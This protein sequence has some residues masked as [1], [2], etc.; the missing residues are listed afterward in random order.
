M[1]HGGS[2]SALATPPCRAPSRSLGTSPR[3]RR[4]PARTSH[5]RVLPRARINRGSDPQAEATTTSPLLSQ[6]VEMPRGCAHDRLFRLFSQATQATGP[7]LHKHSGWKP[8]QQPLA[9]RLK[10][11]MLLRTV[12]HLGLFQK[13]LQ[14]PNTPRH[15]VAPLKSHVAMF[16]LRLPNACS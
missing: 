9:S 10:P 11:K 6:S 7:R 5:L 8:N 2:R 15:S 4:R 1:S 14:L 16:S 13:R 12:E 3:G